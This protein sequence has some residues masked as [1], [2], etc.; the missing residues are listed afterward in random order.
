MTIDT[1]NMYKSSNATSGR[2]TSGT[3]NPNA[4]GKSP[5]A[6]IDTQESKSSVVLSAEAQGLNRLQDKIAS[7]PEI[8]SERVEEIKQAITEGRFSINP[9]RLAEAMLKYEDLLTQP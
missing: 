2:T 3:V 8:N 5:L 4:A 9:E 1:S 7:A 6:A